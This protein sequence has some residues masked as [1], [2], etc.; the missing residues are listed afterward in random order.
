MQPLLN[1]HFAYVITV[2]SRAGAN[3][4]IFPHAVHRLSWPFEDLAAVTGGEA[5]RLAVFRRVRDEIDGRIQ[6][7]LASLAVS[8]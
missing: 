5:E 4:P 8:G 3:C 6:D 7:W 1:E 2:C